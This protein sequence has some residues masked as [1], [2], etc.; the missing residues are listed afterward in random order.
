LKRKFE[1]NLVQSFVVVTQLQE[2][3]FGDNDKAL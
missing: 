3:V 1:L 2:R